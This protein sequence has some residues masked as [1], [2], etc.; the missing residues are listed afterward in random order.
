MIIDAT[1]TVMGRLAST[2]A[3][4][5]LCGENVIIINAE[6]TVITGK[7]KVVFERFNHK[8]VRGDPKNGPFYPRYPDMIIRRVI[9]GML[10]YKKAKGREAIKKLRVF[11][12]N[13]DGIKK[14]ERLVK[15]VDDLQCKYMTLQELSRRMGAKV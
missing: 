4:K 7:K 13:P 10:P 14:A 8:R 2:T 1:N 12:G 11:N 6:K 15:N 9:R 5:L 3:K